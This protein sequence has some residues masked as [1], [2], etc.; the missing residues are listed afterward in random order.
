[1]TRKSDL[2][3]RSLILCLLGTMAQP[4]TAA[5]EVPG[6]KALIEQAKYWRSKGRNDL[7]DQALRRARA[8]DPKSVEAKQAAPKPAPKQLPKPAFGQQSAPVAKAPVVR[9]K[10]AAPAPKRQAEAR[11]PK[12][13]PAS[14]AGTVR[15]AGF[16]ALDAGDIDTAA[17]RFERA[18]TS[19]RNDGDALGGL[20]IVRLRQSRFSEAR[21]LLERASRQ[22]GASRW[23]EALT[24]SRFF[25]GVEDARR[26]LNAGM[27]DKA[28]AI[29][30]DVVRM[31][32]EEPQPA[33][34]ALAEIYEKQGRFADAADL[35]S[36]AGDGGA[37]NESRLRSRAARGRALAAAAQGDDFMAE[38]EFHNGLLIDS[39]DP[40]IRYEFAR[41][42]IRKGRRVEAESLIAS[43]S[44]AT[45]TDAI[46][47]AALVHQD[48]GNA[49]A[50][51]ALIDRIP[52][53]QR[54][55]AMQT[56]AISIKTE[57]AIQ[58]AKAMADVGQK[59][60]AISA[61]RQIGAMST[62]PA[63]R[64]AQVADA[65]FDLNDTAAA[66]S[67]AANALNGEIT[68]LA[69]YDA[70]VRV[71]AKTG[72]EDLARKALQKAAPLGNSSAEGQR[73]LAR[74]S[75]GLAVSQ[76]ER[77][78]L[79]GQFAPAFDL[80]QTAWA[81]MPDDVEVLS[82]IARLYQSGRMPARAAQSFQLVLAREPRNRG[83]LI[84]LAETA[85]A[86]GDRALSARA[87]DK[88]I[89]AWP[90]DYQVRLTLARVAE[91][92]GDKGASVRLLKQA[93]SL[94]TQQNAGA[95]S[96][97]QGGNPFAAGNVPNDGN[98]FRTQA[99]STPP[100]PARINPFALGNGTQLPA[101]GMANFDQ[102]ARARLQPMSANGW[103]NPVATQTRSQGNWDSPAPARS[104]SGWDN[105][106]PARAQSG[107]DNPSPAPS[108]SGW[109]NPS[110]A[111]SQ[112]GWDN[113]APA[114][115][116]GGWGNP[117]PSYSPSQNQFAAAQYQPVPS[118]FPSSTSRNYGSMPMGGSADPIMAGIESDIRALTKN[119]GP[120]VD[121]QTAYRQRKGETG[122]S[123]FS[124]IKGTAELST[125]LLGG[126]AK[127][128]AE[129]VMIDAGRPEGS[130]LARFGR[131]A[132][133]EARSIVNR[134]PSPLVQAATQQASGVAL[135]A[136][137]ENDLVQAEVGT[138]PINMGR[139]KLAFR[140]ALTPR[141]TPNLTAKVWVEKKPVTDSVISYAGTRD[142]VSGERW[143]GVMRT[144]GGVAGSYDS[145]GNGVYGELAYSRYRGR[146]VP[147]NS[148]F[149]ANFGGYLRLFKGE[150]SQL[151]GGIN[152]NYQTY[153]NNQ[154]HFTYGHGG[155]FS[156]QNFVSIGFPIN[157]TLETD[158][159]DV[160]A[161]ITPGFQSFKQ[162]DTA[163][164]PSEPGLQAQLDA[165]KLLNTDVRSR[166]D[167]LSRTGFAITAG[168]SAY[169]RISPTTEIGGNTSFNTFGNFDEFRSTIGIR[170]SIGGTN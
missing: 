69:G 161:N 56:F 71:L 147:N 110:P 139:T 115:D 123:Q 148:S 18:L 53:G 87:S 58:R 46:Y 126:R 40:W 15:V 157:Y 54:T 118:P 70:V 150:H 44:Q 43:L 142:P 133:I 143:G 82:A 12:A 86:A 105:P 73:A 50:A 135:S 163:L 122:L 10:V 20:G 164:Y 78:R 7:A 67:M 51:S 104:Q 95:S 9:Q 112:S 146:I 72:R 151:T 33:L 5:A 16:S 90:D 117:A 31:N 2:L 55:P 63:A 125:G 127:V 64:R 130:G 158:K 89:E 168:G 57:S 88:A 66:S 76:A 39:N 152:A 131:N 156:P 1:M 8:L 49:L 38:Q 34:E 132:T 129:A 96:V 81:S 159:L 144:G 107:W 92:R 98:P 27:T 22:P 121:L 48:L 141:I 26:A 24:T 35:Y 94:Y 99:M 21:D 167:S 29:A 4:G 154:N 30:E 28:Q 32:Y 19:N 83:A 74:M 61:L 119:S 169:Y 45:S 14:T 75:A 140:A 91:Q 124:E 108:Q 42:M 113:P 41:F 103:D 120:R 153:D 100:A 60:G 84:G 77:M 93:R 25:A 145:E 136:G 68:D 17:N 111:P 23:A 134:V 47:A 79:A 102:P 101:V 166:Y 52:E 109:D 80:L 59:A 160:K 165:F 116:Q 65:L 155:Y 6:V 85:Q 36:Q 97:Q 149:E 37:D 162:E 128:R 13:T 62:L 138:T 170:Q 3:Q 137:Y 114:R 11:R 106:V